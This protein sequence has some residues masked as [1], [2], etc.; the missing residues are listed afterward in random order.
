M[1]CG[2]FL[3]AGTPNEQMVQGG[4]DH[5]RMAMFPE[6]SMEVPSAQIMPNQQT[7]M[8]HINQSAQIIQATVANLT[9]YQV[10]QMLKRKENTYNQKKN[11]KKNNKKKTDAS[12]LSKY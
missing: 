7:N 3:H 4:P 10:E 5:M 2:W 6:D 9:T 8:Q 12:H 1:C 11:T